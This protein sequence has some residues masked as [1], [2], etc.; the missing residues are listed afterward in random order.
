M[1]YATTYM[2]NKSL[3]TP[4]AMGV[5]SFCGDDM[6]AKCGKINIWHWAH[7]NL[8]ICDS[9]SDGETEWHLEWKKLFPK[10]WAEINI[11]HNKV[12]HR[13]D[14]QL[15]NKKVIEFQHS[16][17]SVDE[18][19]AREYFYGDMVWIFDIRD[20]SKRKLYDRYYVGDKWVEIYEKPRFDIREK[21]GFQTFRWKHPKK[22]ISQ[23]NCTVYLDL[24][25]ERLFHLKKMS[26]T[27]PCGGW[28]KVLSKDTFIKRFTIY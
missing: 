20:S 6:I 27:T 7:K 28:G 24:G 2:G 15:P 1:L 14:I 12:K 11:S 9:W 22:S 13:A 25:D 26:L 21:E 23:A 10:E 3:A 18:I 16:P 4:S 19:H 17:L 8:D 5:C